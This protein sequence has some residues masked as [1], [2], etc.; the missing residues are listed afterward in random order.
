MREA[1]ASALDARGLVEDAVVLDLF[2][3]TGAMAF[4]ALSRG[5]R[6]AVLVEGARPVA[7]AIEKSARELGL[8]GRVRV[9]NADLARDPAAWL[10]ALEAPVTLVFLDPPYADIARVGP[11]LEA[12]VRADR[13][14]EDATVVVEHATKH[15]PTLP[16]GF[17]EISR[18]RY[19]D[20]SVWLARHAPGPGDT[21]R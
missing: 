8:E 5:A 14:A 4:E 13:I 16:L 10:R 15:P 3:G 20:T 17:E 21:T 6:T 9:V 12:L 11:L 18:Y 1:I 2:A 19:G 7:K